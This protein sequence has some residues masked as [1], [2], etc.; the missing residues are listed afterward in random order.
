MQQDCTPQVEAALARHKK[1]AVDSIC[2][3]FQFAFHTD[4]SAVLERQPRPHRHPSEFQ[5]LESLSFSS[6]ADWSTGFFL[7]ESH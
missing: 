4:A 1:N 3:R 5:P 7:L 6:L 2:L